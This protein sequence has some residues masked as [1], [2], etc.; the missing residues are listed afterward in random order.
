[1]NIVMD[2]K[3]LWHNLVRI[4]LKNRDYDCTELTAKDGLLTLRTANG[5]QEYSTQ[6]HCVVRQPGTL[7]LDSLLLLRALRALPDHYID[8]RHESDGAV[9][10][11]ISLPIGNPLP[12][13]LQGHTT[14][15]L[16]GVYWRNTLM[17]IRDNA[18]AA[19]WIAKLPA[20]V[21]RK[22]ASLRP[23]HIRV[24]EQGGIVTIKAASLTI[25]T[26]TTHSTI[27]KQPHCP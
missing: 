5:S 24:G 20:K 26:K 4:R 19:A 13:P 8:V 16:G 1:M 18:L 21:A 25:R 27:P 9:V 7:V 3:A 17:G 14:E 10:S 6:L 11:R 22:V 12:P 23:V 15:Q 2:R